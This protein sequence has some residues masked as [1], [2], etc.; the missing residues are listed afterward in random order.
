MEKNRIRNHEEIRKTNKTGNGAVRR[1][2]KGK[3]DGRIK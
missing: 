2:G 1:R 3:N